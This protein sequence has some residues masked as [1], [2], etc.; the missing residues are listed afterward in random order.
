MI[1]LLENKI[2]RQLTLI[3]LFLSHQSGFSI[4]SLS[5]KTNVSN[6]TI[7]NDI[8]YLNDNFSAY[9][10]INKEN[11]QS[12]YIKNSNSY[13][14]TKLKDILLNQSKNIHLLTELLLNPFNKIKIY[15]DNTDVSLSSIYKSIDH[16]NLTLAPF[17]ISIERVNN[18][19]FLEA[20]SEILFRKLMSTFLI[21][22]KY[23]VL[24][25]IF[26]N[27]EEP[28]IFEQREQHNLL[29]QISHFKLYYQVVFALSKK[30]EEQGFYLSDEY[31]ENS[32]QNKATE[33]QIIDSMFYYPFNKYF[34]NR[35]FFSLLDYLDNLLEGNQAQIDLLFH[36]ISRIYL[37]EISYQI[38]TYLFTNKLNHFYYNLQEKKYMFKP[39]KHVIEQIAHIL[40]IDLSNYEPFL[41]YIILIYFS[42]F[43]ALK[44]NASI[45]IVSDLSV[46]HAEFLSNLLTHKF[47]TEYTFIP[48]TD[49]K[50]IAA[51]DSSNIFITNNPKLTK[52]NK[53]VI[54][55]YPTD[56]DL[57]Q[58]KQKIGFI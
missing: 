16:I 25:E 27:F 44:K 30:R 23:Y 42:D 36:L 56:N 24:E 41:C 48:I 46:Y 54:N 51:I 34:C 26:T 40:R 5:Q 21:E 37:N 7:L 55:D 9:V 12:I 47:G 32:I 58:I 10:S 19:Y 33:E 28:T 6:Y 43:L 39:I 45:Y 2:Y 4:H 52:S 38:P 14:I 50:T 22:T 35:N 13:K 53:I 8:D 29:L 49:K 31:G 15:A 1:N 3:D 11:L 17:Q 57:N 18:K 20:K